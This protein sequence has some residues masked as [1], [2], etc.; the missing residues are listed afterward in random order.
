MLSDR[1]GGKAI[2]VTGALG[3]IGSHVV[4]ELALAGCKVIP[5][6]S[7]AHHRTR[8]Y[9]NGLVIG[10]MLDPHHLFAWLEENSARVGAIVHL[11]AISDTTETDL[12]LLDR[13]NVVFSMEL[14]HRAAAHDW[15]FIYASSAATYGSGEHGFRDSETLSYLRMLKPLNAYGASKHRVDMRIIEAVQAGARAPHVWAGLK[16]FNVYGPH[17]QHK[18]EMR[19]IVAKI[20]PCIVAGEPVRL[21]RSE[22]PDYPD[23]G[24]KRDFIYVRDAVRPILHALGKNSLAGLFNVGTGQASTF[25]DLVTHTFS[26]L[27][28]E[29]DIEFIELPGKLQGAYQYFTEADVTKAQ[30]HGLHDIRFDLREAVHEYVGVLTGL[31]MGEANAL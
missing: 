8:R 24:Q 25:L 13:N 27:N 30:T 11:G 19:S 5:C 26:A 23:G 3:L 17:E 21:F 14:W 12:E 16:F 6:D 22:H 10:D 15:P 7:V 4:R 20:V 9:L 1:F 2:V 28:R 31:A 18:G 29:P